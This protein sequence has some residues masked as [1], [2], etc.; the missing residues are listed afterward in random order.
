[1]PRISD[2]YTD[3]AVYI[4]ASRND[5]ESGVLQGGSGFIVTLPFDNDPEN[6]HVHTY[7]VTNNHVVESAKT[8][9]IRLNRRDGQMEF[10]ETTAHEWEPHEGGDD[11]S[12]FPLRIGDR[13]KFA[14][15]P[16]RSFVTH[17]LVEIEDIGIGDDTVMI[18]RFINH[19]GKQKNSPAVRFG[20]IAMMAKDKIKRPDGFEQESF[21][22]ETR[23]LPGYSG[24]AVLLYSPCAMNDMSVRR[25]G[26][27]KAS[28]NPMSGGGQ[29]KFDRDFQ[30]SF[31]A[32][33]PYLL[34]I[35]WCHLPSRTHVLNRD[36]S[37][38]GMV[39]DENTGMAGV[40]PAWKI[41]EVLYSERQ[42]TM[43]KR[44]PGIGASGGG[45]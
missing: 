8:P 17:S 5:A 25:Y 40:I 20:N 31:S 21:L 26:V 43:R 39:V 23:S 29:E 45:C 6:P 4:Y 42:Q 36:G 34:G 1:M 37:K 3:C 19:E 27:E 14:A 18:G 24:S 41:I 10:I 16:L 12:V 33:G 22:V 35:D 15:M 38:T 7:V 28:V 2:A 9:V 13:F 11:V 32:K 30:V 44:E